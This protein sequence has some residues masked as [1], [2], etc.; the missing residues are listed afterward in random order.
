[1]MSSESSQY[2]CESDGSSPFRIEPRL[3]PLQE[4]EMHS[5][6][7]LRSLGGAAGSVQQNA[8][9]RSSIRLSAHSRS[10]SRQTTPPC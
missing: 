1:M 6:S 10:T 4:A 3:P 5:D 2:F 7:A 9:T 8:R